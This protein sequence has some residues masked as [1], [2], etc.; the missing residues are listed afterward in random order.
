M[1]LNLGINPLA[2]PPLPQVSIVRGGGAF[3]NRGRDYD[4]LAMVSAKA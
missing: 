3:S 1:T 4:D 2:L